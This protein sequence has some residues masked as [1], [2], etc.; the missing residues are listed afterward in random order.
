MKTVVRLLLP[1]LFALFCFAYPFA[2]IGVA[3]DV[4][5]PFSMEW[6]GSTLL[7][8]EGCVLIAAAM[9]LYGVIRALMVGLTVIVL[10]Y[11]VETL[12]VNT[13]FP[14]GIYR[15]TP[16]LFPRLPGGVPLA[17]MFAWVFIVLGAYGWVA[18][19]KGRI[20][21]PGALLG[22]LLA[23]LLDFV[24][25][26]VAFHVVGYWQW[27]QAGSF[28]YYDVPF[29]NF[30]AWFVVAFLLLLLVDSSFSR[31]HLQSEKGLKL[32]RRAP[33]L[34]FAA[35][36]FMFGLVDLTHG[37]IFAAVIALAS[38]C[39]LLSLLRKA[40]NSGITVGTGW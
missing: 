27:L 9:R 35:S 39:L 22:A 25:E 3:F 33:K 13:G 30:F 26:P 29:T 21:L 18:R 12:G 38:G 16:I 6:A 10:S 11:C 31:I 1:V 7:F 24:I 8:I 4:R 34:L 14:F 32:A 36:L 23:M 15:Y 40:N 2:V 17:V 19:G 20:G 5:P 28:N 37:Y